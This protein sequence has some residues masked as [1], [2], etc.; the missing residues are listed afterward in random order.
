MKYQFH[1]ISFAPFLGGTA[2]PEQLLQ[3]AAGA[4][5]RSVAI[6][7][8]GRLRARAAHPPHIESLASG[9]CPRRIRIHALHRTELARPARWSCAELGHGTA[10]LLLD[11]WHL[12]AGPDSLKSLRDLHAEEIATVH[13]DGATP[14]AGEDLGET[15]RRVMPGEGALDLEGFARGIVGTGYDGS[16][17]LEV[18]NPTVASG[19]PALFARDAMSCSQRY[20]PAQQKKCR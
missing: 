11:P 18:L 16:V 20:W 15:R 9:G 12:S 14:L 3:A 19:D 13:F 7:R 6:D 8:S 10:S 1:T 17:A 2:S 5:F 4:G